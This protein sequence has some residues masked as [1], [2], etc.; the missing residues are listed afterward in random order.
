VTTVLPPTPAP[1]AS[2][3]A[4][5]TATAAGGITVVLGTAEEQ[6]FLGDPGVGN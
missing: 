4:V 5:P 6:A 1:T 3:A 2:G